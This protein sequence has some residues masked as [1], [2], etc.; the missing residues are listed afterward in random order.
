MMM[1]RTRPVVVN[2]GREILLC[3]EFRIES[4]S[5]LNEEQTSRKSYILFHP[6]WRLP[7]APPSPKLHKDIAPLA[8]T[9][10]AICQWS[11]LLLR[12]LEN[13]L[14]LLLL[15]LETFP[16]TAAAAAIAIPCCTEEG[17][18]G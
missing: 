4:S 15:L 13:K 11:T 12:M 3:G 2:C 14:D 17:L 5:P 1:M 7:L 16:E 9:K 10:V 6:R 8:V 18:T